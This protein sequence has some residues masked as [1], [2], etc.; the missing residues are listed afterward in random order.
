MAAYPPL[1]PDAIDALA[2]AYVE[3]DHDLRA[4]LRVLFNSDFFKQA[5]FRRV[6]SPTEVIIGTL[7]KT[8][9]Y[10]VPDGGDNGIFM[11]MEESGFMGQ[12]LLDPPSVEGWHTGEEWITSGSL[13]DRVNFAAQ[14]LGDPSKPGV[15]NLVS[16]VSGASDPSDPAELVDACLDVLGPMDVSDDTRAM[17]VDLASRGIQ[18][19]P[20]GRASQELILSLFKLIVSSREYQLC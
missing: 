18:A 7:R 8:G 6:K 17:L 10:A 11:I 16:R 20:T 3:H 19:E 5:R 14:R 12:K 4:V 1:D 9:E 15:K 13:V 2:A